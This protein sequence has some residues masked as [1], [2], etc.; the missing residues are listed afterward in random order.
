MIKIKI[1]NHDQIVKNEK[2][3][4]ISKI[5]PFFVDVEKRVEEAI[6]KEIRDIFRQKKI[7]AHIQITTE[8]EPANKNNK[9]KILSNSSKPSKTKVTKTST[10][11]NI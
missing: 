5:A 4:W 1:K 7:K 10:K 6:V 11:T 9:S 8:E 2:N 3:W